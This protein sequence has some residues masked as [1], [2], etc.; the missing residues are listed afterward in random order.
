MIIYKIKAIISAIGII[1]SLLAPLII[2][3]V[4]LILHMKKKYDPEKYYEYSDS[5]ARDVDKASGASEISRSFEAKNAE[6]RRFELITVNIMLLAAFIT[7]LV[8]LMTLVTSDEVGKIFI[9]LLE[10]S[11]LLTIAL[12]ILAILLFFI[13]SIIAYLIIYAVCIFIVNGLRGIVR[14]FASSVRI[15]K[16][17]GKEHKS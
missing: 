8:T 12:L 13:A 4:F 15:T 17:N 16:S 1:I 5:F 9:L 14:R 11:W 2:L 6:K 7:M 10:N 3:L